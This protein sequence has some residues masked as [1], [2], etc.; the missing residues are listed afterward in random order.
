MYILILCVLMETHI[1]LGQQ[2]WVT[3]EDLVDDAMEGGKLSPINMRTGAL[4]Y[5]SQIPRRASMAEKILVGSLKSKNRSSSIGSYS[6]KSTSVSST[7][8]FESDCNLNIST[9]MLP[10][11]PKCLSKRT[12]FA[13]NPNSFKDFSQSFP[14][15]CG[16]LQVFSTENVYSTFKH[17]RTEEKLK[18]REGGNYYKSTDM[19]KDLVEHEKFDQISS[20]DY[21]SNLKYSDLKDN[22]TMSLYMPCEE[23]RPSLKTGKRSL[24]LTLGSPLNQQQKKEKSQRDKYEAITTVKIHPEHGY[25]GWSTTVL[26]TGPFGWSD[27]LL[28]GYSEPNVRRSIYS[29]QPNVYLTII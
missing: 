23:L 19:N 7:N 6:M 28:S 18:D 20:S 5:C 21:E 2:K 4:Q 17:E 15:N 12:S 14:G 10:K 9:N 3:F 27:E 16:G 22:T 1:Y 26:G 8:S 24:Q 13:R 11:P 29:K 25:T